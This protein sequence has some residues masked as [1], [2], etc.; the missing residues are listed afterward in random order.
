MHKDQQNP[1]PNI[2]TFIKSLPILAAG[3]FMA[4]NS[5]SQAKSSVTDY[6]G[7][8]KP[9]SFDNLKEIAGAK[10]AELKQLKETNP[11]VNYHTFAKGDEIML[12]YLLSQNTPD[13]KDISILE[14]NVY[15]YKKFKDRNGKVAL[16]LFA[17]SERAY[18]ND[19]DK[20]LL[21]L[22]ANR[23]ALP[24][25]VAAFKLPELTISK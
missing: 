10:V 21:G 6:L 9:I 11:M 8:A 19:V 4:L 13:G 17:V 18:G 2:M 23:L 20:F 22:K 25:A 12:D 5:S 16:L 24:I 15:R 3:I 14:R 7:L 1:K